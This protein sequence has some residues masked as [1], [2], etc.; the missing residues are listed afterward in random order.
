M[1]PV[2]IARALGTTVEEMNRRN[3]EACERIAKLIA[4]N[5][6]RDAHGN[7]AATFQRAA[8]VLRRRNAPR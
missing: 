1:S 4:A 8:E 7:T 6:G 5:G 3:A 2:D